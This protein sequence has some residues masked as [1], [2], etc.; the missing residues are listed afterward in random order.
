[1][2][3]A[4]SG[5][6]TADARQPPRLPAGVVAVL[7]P[8]VCIAPLVLAVMRD[9]APT[10]TWEIAAA[11]LGLVGLA[12]MA[13]QFVTSGRFEIVS[14]RLGI[15]RV[16]AF[17]KTAAWWVL[18]ALLL[19]PVVYVVPTFVADPALGVERLWAYHTL[20]HYRSGVIALSALILLV[21]GSAVR[22]RLP[23]RY[24]TWRAA[25]LVLAAVAL[26]AGLHH[27]VTA[28]R[29]SAGGGLSTGTGGPWARPW[30][31]SSPS[32]MAGAG[33]NCACGHGG[34][35]PSRRWPTGCGSSTSSPP[36]G[37]L[38]SATARASSSG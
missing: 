1:M 33:R 6:A 11:G 29:F 2:Q 12:A 34:S 13:V 3:D 17:H 25:H 16:M 31:R 8:L 38:H 28:G 4:R 23:L 27:A 7:Y 22:K 15:D 19:H 32:F 21:L 30:W 20:P 24:E 35:P 10:V 37:R 9:V 14:G 18:V 36:R 5:T 26:G